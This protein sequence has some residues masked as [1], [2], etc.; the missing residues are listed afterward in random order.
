MRSVNLYNYGSGRRD[1]MGIV[2]PKIIGRR[3]SDLNKR[4]SND[5]AVQLDSIEQLL[6][7]IEA[8]LRGCEVIHYS[9]FDSLHHGIL[10]GSFNPRDLPLTTDVEFV[11][12]T[13][14]RQVTLTYAD[15]F[16]YREAVHMQFQ[17]FVLLLSSFFE[18]VV[19]LSEILLKKVV[20]HGKKNKPQSIPLPEYLYH[21]RALTELGYR[22]HDPLYHCYDRHSLFLDKYL[23]TL[24]SLRNSYIHGYE[25]KLSVARTAPGGPEKYLLTEC[26]RPLLPGSPELELGSFT[27]ELLNGTTAFLN[28]LL[29]ALKDAVADPGAT[30][31]A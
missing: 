1:L 28:D 9:Y 13:S 11:E 16:L 8:K 19:R 6:N 3:F 24:V 15:P 7:A 4:F 10:A 29:A 18:N 21:L 20:L 26:D 30:L 5:L 2:E 14:R 22:G 23:P 12:G 27:A 25:T 31:P 17:Q